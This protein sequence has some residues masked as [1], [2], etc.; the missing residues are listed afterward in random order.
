MANTKRSLMMS[1]ISLILCVSML[2][3]S[4]FAW[5]TD[6]SFSKNNV[7]QT[8]NLKAEMYWADSQ[9]D[10][11]D[12]RRDG[13]RNRWNVAMMGDCEKVDGCDVTKLGA[14]D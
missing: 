12:Q 3:G 10:G 6:V 2:L 5:F 7:I 14:K 11:I 13:L 9:A 4:T 1:A 8:G